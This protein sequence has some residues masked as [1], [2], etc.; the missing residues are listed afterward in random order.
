MKDPEVEELKKRVIAL[1]LNLKAGKKADKADKKP[2]KPSEY[3]TF[4]GKFIPEY[5]KDHP[6]ASH[7]D[8]FAAG[9]TAWGKEK[10]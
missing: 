10:K 5:K 9:A 2:R 4:M 1:E 3:N 7:K 6:K 8:A